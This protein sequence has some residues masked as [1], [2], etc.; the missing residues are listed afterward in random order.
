MPE[1]DRIEPDY[2]TR[3]ISIPP[4]RSHEG[5]RDMEAFI[6]EVG[7]PHLQRRLEDAIDGRGAFRR[8]KNVLYDYP[9]ERQLWYQ[10]KRARLWQ[11]MIAWLESQE[12]S[13]IL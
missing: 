13:P 10:F 8:F 2:G 7:D 4:D 11:R 9:A 1:V 5:Y 12:I 3:F 6:D